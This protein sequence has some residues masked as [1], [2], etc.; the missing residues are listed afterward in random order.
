MDHLK[1]TQGDSIGFVCPCHIG[2]E[3]KHRKSIF[4]LES[5]GFKV[6]VGNNVYKNTHGYLAT[7]KERADDFNAMA[8]DDQ[9]KM[10][11][12]GGGEGGNELLPHLDYTAL[13]ANPKLICGFSD[14]TT[15]LNAIHAL[16]GLRVYYGQG[17]GMFNELK[18]YDYR[19]FHARFIAAEEREWIASAP[20]QTLFPGRARGKLLGGYLRNFA[21]LLG[22]PYFKYNPQEK[23][24]LF[25]EDHETFSGVAKVSSFLSHIEQSDF[26]HTVSG[27]IWGHYAQQTPVDLLNRLARFGEKHQVPVVYTDDF[28]HGV[29][30]GILPIGIQGTLDATNKK[31]W[32]EQ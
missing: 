17:P 19:H 26:I 27:L 28:G 24:L 5:L 14:G 21:L 13:R 12:F 16:T 18:H 15:L 22:S 10:I 31:L 25:L 8:K 2:S 32:F 23:H 6:K 20:W 1:L 9:V 30:H 29:Y 7:P 4:T 3:E 11:L